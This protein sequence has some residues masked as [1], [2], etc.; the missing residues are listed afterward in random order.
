MT[1]KQQLMA[2]QLYGIFATCFLF[3]S[4]T[5]IAITYETD[6]EIR[7]EADLLVE[8][9]EVLYEDHQKLRTL[10]T[11]AKKEHPEKEK[12]MLI[13]QESNFY[14]SPEVKLTLSQQKALFPQADSLY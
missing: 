7:Q 14:F 3:T 4:L 8:K 1:A 10:Y 9:T 6:K 5:G 12:L 2:A 13:E 11:I